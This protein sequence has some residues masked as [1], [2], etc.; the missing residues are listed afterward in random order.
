M[1]PG[2]RRIAR[3]RGFDA[4]RLG[5]GRPASR[6]P[7]TWPGRAYEQ[8]VRSRAVP[9]APGTF[10]GAFT[11]G[12]AARVR[13]HAA[14]AAGSRSGSGRQLA[15]AA[16]GTRSGFPP[17]SC[18]PAWATR[19]AER[20]TCTCWGRPAAAA[21]WS[22][23][24]PPPQL[25]RLCRRGPV[26][27]LGPSAVCRGA[28]S[29]CRLRRLIVNRAG[30]CSSGRLKYAVLSGRWHGRRLSIAPATGAGDDRRP[31]ERWA[32]SPRA[33]SNWAPDFTTIESSPVRP[34][35][36][37]V[38]LRPW[39]EQ[40]AIRRITRHAEAWKSW[41]PTVADTTG[42]QWRRPTSPAYPTT[43]FGTRGGRASRR[44]RWPALLAGG[45]ER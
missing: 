28:S 14:D 3:R 32:R 30:P 22:L 36:T 35:T 15:L 37:P 9:S 6:R 1:S 38:V 4:G 18:A 12:T 24:A 11:G 13:Q 2:R 5:R 31:R 44:R 16:G 39:Q 10:G 27:I 42:L 19:N 7:A 20:W 40:S 26:E 29:R 33:P 41:R 45:A 34:D 23:A 43:S 21:S 17:A 8:H 25:Q